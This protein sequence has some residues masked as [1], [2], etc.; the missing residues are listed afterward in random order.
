MNLEEFK[1]I[2]MAENSKWDWDKFKIVCKK[3]HSEIVEFNG[4]CESESGYYGEHGLQGF[5]VVKCHECGNAFKIDDISDSNSYEFNTDG[6][7]IKQFH[8]E[9]ERYN[10]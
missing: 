7:N 8:R 9:V 10:K 3:C 2:Y 4:Y 6:G 1:K 5:I